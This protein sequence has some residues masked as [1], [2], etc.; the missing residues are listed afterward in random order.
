MAGDPSHL[1]PALPIILAMFF[2]IGDENVRGGTFPLFSYSFI[3]LN[4]LIFLFEISLTP[5][6]LSSL[7][8]DYGAVPNEIVRGEDFHSLLTSMF[9]HGGWMHLIGNMLFLWVF[10]D[11]IE[12][13]VGNTRF[14]IFYLLG[15]F[16]AAFA[17]I[18]F[19]LDSPI[20]MVGA[21]GAIS[22]VMGA[23]LVMYPASKIKVL[24]FIFPFRVPAFIFLGLWI[25]EQTI[26]GVG[27]LE[28]ATASTSG[29]AW[30]AHIGGFAFGLLSGFIF[31]AAGHLKY[32]LE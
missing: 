23:Y 12:A 31:R 18:F 1:L 24:F 32:D 21:S 2:P 8:Q 30:W 17:H 14:F 3:A 15:G 27:D 29:V 16:A 4:I 28:V 25:F 6:A 10:A 19:N 22:A 9:L 7:F 5:G 26:N 13:T 20:P 11:N